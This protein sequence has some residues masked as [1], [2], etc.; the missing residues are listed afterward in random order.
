MDTSDELII[1]LLVVIRKH[2][3]FSLGDNETYLVLHALQI[4]IGSE[5]V[6]LTLKAGTVRRKFDSLRNKIGKKRG[7]HIGKSKLNSCTADLSNIQK[8][9]DTS[10]QY[11]RG[12]LQMTGKKENTD[13][14]ARAKQDAYRRDQARWRWQAKALEQVNVR[15]L[16]LTLQLALFVQQRSQ[17]ALRAQRGRMDD[18][19]DNKN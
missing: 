14:K 9:G 7:K 12:E 18:Q 10:E 5:F 8:K 16:P 4:G 13:I 2:I 3:I 17:I 11:K 1:V 19:L 15:Q 6:K